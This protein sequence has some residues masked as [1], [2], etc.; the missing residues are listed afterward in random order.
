[1]K[2]YINYIKFQL[3][4]QVNYFI[5]FH[6]VVAVFMIQSYNIINY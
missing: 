4:T 6:N 2:I 1:M 3:D 5:E